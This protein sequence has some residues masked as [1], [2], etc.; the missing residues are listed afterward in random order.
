MNEEF[1]KYMD[2]ESIFGKLVAVK[3]CSL[4]DARFDPASWWSNFGATTPNI[5]RLSMRILSLTSSSFGCERNWSTFEGDKG[6]IQ[7][8]EIDL[9][10][11]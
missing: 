5:Q 11:N 7:K 10:Q 8:R 2:N 9:V 3:G 6:Y 1:S 4:N